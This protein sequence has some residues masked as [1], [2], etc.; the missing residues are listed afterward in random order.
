[1]GCTESIRYFRAMTAMG[2]KVADEAPIEEWLD[3]LAVYLSECL[4]TSW[5]CLCLVSEDSGW[6]ETYVWKH[7][8]RSSHPTSFPQQELCLQ[9]LNTGLPV[10]AAGNDFVPAPGD[11]L[12]Q[13]SRDKEEIQ[14]VA[15]PLIREGHVCGALGVDRIFFSPI[16]WSEDILALDQI[17]AYVLSC[18][19]LRSRI[20][21]LKARNDQLILDQK[22]RVWPLAFLGPSQVI[23]EV[24]EQVEQAAPAEIPILLQGEPGTHKNVLARVLHERSMRNQEPFIRVNCTLPASVLEGELF[25]YT[26]TAFPQ[27]NVGSKGAFEAAERG[28]LYLDQIN[29]LPSKLQNRILRAVQ[30]QSVER[31]GDYTSRRINVRIIAS[32]SSTLSHLVDRGLF[33]SELFYRMNRFP[34]LLPPLRE[35]REDI[36][37]ML[38]HALGSREEGNGTNFRF[39]PP[40]LRLLQ[41]YAWPGNVRELEALSARILLTQTESR[42]SRRQILELLY[43]PPARVSPSCGWEREELPPM[44]IRD[45][46]KK[47]ILAALRRHGG[48]QNRAA[49]ELGISP[50][51]LGYRISKYGLKETMRSMR[52]YARQVEE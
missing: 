30:D 29:S 50:R 9:A 18:L 10:V 23:D 27:A 4:H 46:E 48:S 38:T 7:G 37:T 8:V 25:G 14:A 34:I 11:E 15:A 31:L 36:E 47:A 44:P 2:A 28:T 5:I 6:R 51:Q 17:A 20:Q 41:A 49:Q 3:E 43:P 1:M 22:K 42:I 40:A 35:R 16:P 52:R 33:R 24:R 21:T 32:S 39:T 12:L 26:H 45:L 13:F 19:H